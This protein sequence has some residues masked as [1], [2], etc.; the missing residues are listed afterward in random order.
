M[1]FEYF[2]L[3]SEQ[4]LKMMVFISLILAPPRGTQGLVSPED[5][6]CPPEKTVL[7][8]VPLCICTLIILICT[9]VCVKAI[10]F[11]LIA[12]FHVPFVNIQVHTCV[13]ELVILRC[14]TKSPSCPWHILGELSSPSSVHCSSHNSPEQ[15]CQRAHKRGD[16]I[17]APEHEVCHFCLGYHRSRNTFRH[18]IFL[19]QF[20][21]VKWEF[22]FMAN[23]CAEA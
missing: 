11:S 9:H 22:T 19:Y 17:M 15:D 13:I 5:L 12:S 8:S 16:E 21:G 10:I 1:S 23:T 4:T 14:W 2:G 7:L 20:D 6:S 18:S 3:M